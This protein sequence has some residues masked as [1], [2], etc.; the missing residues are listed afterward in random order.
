MKNTLAKPAGS[1]ESSSD[2]SSEVGE[3]ERVINAILSELVFLLF[4]LTLLHTQTNI[5]ETEV[6]VRKPSLPDMGQNYAVIDWLP[7]SEECWTPALLSWV[8]FVVFFF[9]FIFFFSGNLRT[10]LKRKEQV[11]VAFTN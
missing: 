10:D 8:L 1:G 2:D 9:F 5:I 7:G 3:L 11:L 4:Q 6:Q